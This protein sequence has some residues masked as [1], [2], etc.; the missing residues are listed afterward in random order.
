MR[1]KILMPIDGK[2]KAVHVKE[3]EMI[4]KEFLMVEIE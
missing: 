3:G 2:I 4:P 1:N